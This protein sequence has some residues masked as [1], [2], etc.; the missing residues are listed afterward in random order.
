MLNVYQLSPKETFGS[1]MYILESE[2]E[3]AVIDPSV[4]FSSAAAR[5]PALKHALKYVI[6]THAH[7]DHFLEI[8]SWVGNTDASV[9]VGQFDARALSDPYKN[10]YRIFFG[11]EKGYYG[12]FTEVCE[13]DIFPFGDESFT[14]LSTPG[15]TSGGISLLFKNEIFVGDTVFA[16]GGYGRYDLPGGDYEALT[17]SLHRI[18]NMDKHLTVYPGHGRQTDINEIYAFFSNF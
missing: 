7:F 9:L 17:Y 5:F 13:G 8:D 11:Q 18:A 1:N 2:N 16:D 3:Y 6:L 15:H 4:D 14:V 12:K 10:A